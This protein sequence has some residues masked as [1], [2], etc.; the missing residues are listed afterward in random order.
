MAVLLKRSKNE[1]LSDHNAHFN[2]EFIFIYLLK[3]IKP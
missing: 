2:W 3:Q 1:H